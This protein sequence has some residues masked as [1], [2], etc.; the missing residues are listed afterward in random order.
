MRR[1]QPFR[2]LLAHVLVAALFLVLLGRLWQV[3]ILD[4]ERYTA[5]AVADHVRH[6]VVPAVRGRILDDR[7][8]PLARNK[9]AMTVFADRVALTRQPDRGRATLRELAKALGRPYKDLQDR[10]RLC[11]PRTRQ[12]C[13]AGSPYEP[14]PVAEGVGE[15]EAMQ[16]AERPEDFPGITAEPRPVRDHPRGALA[17]H[18]LGYL[19]PGDSND[20]VGKDG[21][22]ATYESDLRGRP[23]SRKV[24]VDSAGQVLRTLG[25]QPATPGATVVTSIDADVQAV[26][27]RALER[28]VRKAGKADSG[29]AVV[30]DVRTG[31]V[32]ALAAAPSYDPE[33]W[34][35]GIGEADYRRL[36]SGAGS[37]LVS[38]AVQGLW[39]PASTWKVVSTAAAA[40]AGYDLRG[41]Y[42]CPG[43][44]RIGDRSFRNYGGADL[45][46]MD[47]RR[48]LV[49]S[50]DTI[51]Y[52]FAERLQGGTAMQ[53]MARGFG[54]GVATGVDLPG[55]AAGRVPDPA[56]KKAYWKQTKDRSCR[57]ARTGY[58]QEK[59]AARAAY[60]KAVAA[61]NCAHGYVWT[62]GDAANFSIGQ[63][64]VL[65]T[66]LQLARAYAAL[67][68]GGTLFSPRVAK[69]VRGP[70]GTLLREVTPPVA[71]RLPV[72]AATL[73]FMRDALAE[74]PRSGTAAGA[75]DGFPLG[76]LP[77]AGKT[78]TAEAYGAEDTS[79]FASFAPAG[80]PRYAVVVVVSRGGGGGEAA[81]P[82]VREIWSGMY[83]LEGRK[84]A[85]P[86]DKRW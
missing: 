78:G 4:G 83:G 47:L 86:R 30:L 44:Y 54:F 27:E 16:I 68:N 3:Q 34:T 17:A 80:K 12:P 63:G 70:D 85:L 20:L 69:E 13:W 35:G 65:V 46:V 60:L 2:L 50:C 15:R 39:P 58:P 32:V 6:V 45:G 18:V 49:V 9:A 84:P 77:V 57:A 81:A 42:D 66:P 41:R 11:G 75:F 73:E 51:F 74:V 33:I 10:M 25:E 21:L 26:V 62:A 14:I 64:D 52:R 38:R 61:E 43:S 79:W 5:A 23:G 1:S 71:G 24:V 28:A 59:D 7:G 55:E 56:W 67:A 19:A 76:K 8:R 82:A 22:E 48:A 29:A 40:K 37:P 72:P 31:R 53:D 36:T